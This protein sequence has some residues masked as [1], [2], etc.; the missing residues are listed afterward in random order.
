M[1]FFFL[2]YIIAKSISFFVFLDCNDI[3]VQAFTIGIVPCWERSTFTI[4]KLLIRVT[5][6]G[7][8]EASHH[9]SAVGHCSYLYHCY[10]HP[11]PDTAAV[12][13]RENTLRSQTCDRG[14]L[15]VTYIDLNSSM[16]DVH[17]SPVYS[18]HNILTG[19][20]TIQ[21]IFKM[22]CYAWWL[23]AQ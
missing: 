6:D 16:A 13:T 21:G 11:L 15:Q 4:F 3:L 23:M 22:F 1:Y 5:Q 10:H 2:H 9:G 12:T 18:V 17:L 19:V 20:S 8:V 14:E 7:T